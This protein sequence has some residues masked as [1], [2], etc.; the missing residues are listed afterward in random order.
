MRPASLLDR[1]HAVFHKL[2]DRQPA[3]TCGLV[4]SL[5]ASAAQ[6]SLLLCQL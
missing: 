4:R 1:Q 5:P 2:K 3:E 6:V